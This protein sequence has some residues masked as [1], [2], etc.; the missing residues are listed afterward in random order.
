MGT[1]LVFN[2]DSSSKSRSP[3]TRK[4]TR[5]KRVKIDGKKKGILGKKKF[6]KYEKGKSFNQ[7]VKEVM[8]KGNYL[9][10]GFIRK[11]LVNT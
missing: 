11:P 1:T 10:E 8:L 7:K 4:A 2:D 3:L 9:E 5:Y 6:T